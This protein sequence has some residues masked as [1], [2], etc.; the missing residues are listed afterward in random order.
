[1]EKTS[2]VSRHYILAPACFCKKKV[3]PIYPNGK[4]RRKCMILLGRLK[5]RVKRF[6]YLKLYFISSGKFFYN[7]LSFLV[8]VANSLQLFK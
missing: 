5:K 4:G 2:S 1:M 6:V 8:L 3:G 7:F